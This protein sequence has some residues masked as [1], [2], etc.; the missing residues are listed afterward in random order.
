MIDEAVLLRLLTPPIYLFDDGYVRKVYGEVGAL[1]YQR[2]E[3]D[4]A[5][6]TCPAYVKWSG[7]KHQK[8]RAGDFG[9][10]KGELPEASAYEY[11]TRVLEGA[12]VA[13]Y[14]FDVDVIPSLVQ[15]VT[16]S[17]PDLA[18][19]LVVNLIKMSYGRMGLRIMRLERIGDEQRDDGTS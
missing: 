1:K 17:V 3:I 4:D 11:V 18:Y 16:V 7:C 14:R 9:W 10:V 19:P 2:Y 13:G 12:G 15:G 6:C 8:M 5:R